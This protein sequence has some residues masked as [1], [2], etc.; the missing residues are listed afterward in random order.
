MTVSSIS[1]QV[2]RATVRREKIDQV[3]SILRDRKNIQD[4][5]TKH[6]YYTNKIEEGPLR[7]FGY[8]KRMNN[9]NQPVKP[10]SLTTSDRNTPPYQPFR[11]QIFKTDINFVYYVLSFLR[12]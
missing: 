2:L 10:I 8:A 4:K 1:L 7:W 6:L 3:I 12:I 11:I 5:I 9:R